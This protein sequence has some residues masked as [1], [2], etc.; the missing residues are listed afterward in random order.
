MI[1]FVPGSA[2]EAPSEAAISGIEYG[3]EQKLPE[4]YK[5]F[6][7]YA[8]GAKLKNYSVK[9][10]DK[11]FVV[12]FFL[13]IIEKYQDHP[14]GWAEVGV[15]ASQLFDR[16]GDDPDAT[17]DD[18]VPIAALFAGDFLVLDYRRNS[19]EPEVSRWYHETS[20]PF[21]PDAVPVAVSFGDFL[22]HLK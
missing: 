7:K 3:S 8:N 9:I 12:E 10:G 19:I 14:Y 5:K 11:E 22:K 15:V 4:S 1:D 18:L 13:P 20:E 16:L 21:K 2:I 6:L 17:G